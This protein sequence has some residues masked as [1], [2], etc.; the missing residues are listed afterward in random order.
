MSKKDSNSSYLITLVFYMGHFY[1]R[2]LEVNE[3]LKAMSCFNSRA[4][5]NK[6]KNIQFYANKVYHM[7]IKL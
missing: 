5:N 1:E 4:F 2:Y 3:T 6:Y 7:I